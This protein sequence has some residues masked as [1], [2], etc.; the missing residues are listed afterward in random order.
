MREF[1]SA[2][3]DIVFKALFVRNPDLLR[4][5]LRDVLDLD[6]SDEDEVTILN[7]ELIPLAIDGKLSRLDVHV[8]TA[9]QKF[10]IEMQARSVG[11]NAERILYYWSQMYG[12]DF[13]AGE[14]YADLVQTFSVNILGY[15]FLNCPEY[16]SS[17]SLR[18]DKRHE[19]LTDKMSVHVFELPK[20]PKNLV[21]SDN[22]QM[23]MELIRANSEEALSMVKN[24][25]QNPSIQ[26]AVDAVHTINADEAFREQVR[27]REKALNDY[28]NEI[29]IV[30]AE[31]LAEGL[32]K[33]RE[34]SRFDT[35]AELVKEGV[36]D[37][38][39]AAKKANVSVSEFAVKAGLTG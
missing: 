32:A 19:K 8:R 33:G 2:S 6:I 27:L 10:N 3:H 37:V 21:G 7:E 30:R 26:E 39:I 28:Y 29:N 22:V 20:V 5:F 31:G 17:Y 18:E 12:N 25:A 36:L 1:L 9:T 11:F 24:T 34:E 16:H 35:L 13:K 14:E 4:A 38:V 15:N 23:W